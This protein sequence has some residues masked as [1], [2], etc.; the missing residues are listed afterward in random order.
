MK[1]SSQPTSKYPVS[2]GRQIIADA[3]MGSLERTDDE[4]LPTKR[5]GVDAGLDSMC[6]DHVAMTPDAEAVTTSVAVVLNDFRLEISTICVIEPVYNPDDG[7]L[8]DICVG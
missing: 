2:L 7:S 1:P 5:I 8:I 4:L 6:I 3:G